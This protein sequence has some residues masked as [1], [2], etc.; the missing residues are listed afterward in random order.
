MNIIHSPFHQHSI[1]NT[2]STWL[3]T[4]SVYFTLTDILAT[5]SLWAVNRL[6]IS[7]LLC[8]QIGFCAYRSS[9]FVFLIRLRSL[10][11]GNRR[12][13]ENELFECVWC[14]SFSLLWFIG[15]C[16]IW[17]MNIYFRPWPKKIWPIARNIAKYITNLYNAGSILV[18]VWT[19]ERTIYLLINPK[20]KKR[21]KKNE[22]DKR[23]NE[24]MNSNLYSF[25][26]C[27]NK[28]MKF[29]WLV[30]HCLSFWC[31]NMYNMIWLT[32]LR[33]W[34]EIPP[35]M[36]DDLVIHIPKLVAFCPSIHHHNKEI[37]TRAPF[38]H[39]PLRYPAPATIPTPSHH[40]LF[41]WNF[42]GLRSAFWMTNKWKSISNRK[43][44]TT[45]HEE[46][47]HRKS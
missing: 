41:I 11:I 9:A 21:K 33:K 2:C 36:N 29:L 46:W 28:Y 37:D 43:I 14:Q 8:Y 42:D 13:K 23:D 3:L 15:I 26:W 17:E 40:Y 6:T 24:N 31:L 12:T 27:C 1:V 10:F 39:Y 32:R 47:S 35:W 19:Y 4:V 18:G 22:E 16:F 34:W 25:R 7:Q 20:K 30:A 45:F 44:Y 5:P 38:K